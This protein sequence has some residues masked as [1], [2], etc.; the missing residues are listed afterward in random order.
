MELKKV[1]AVR[2]AKTVYRD[3][4]KA[5]K[6]FGDEYKKSDI[7]NEALNQ[8]RVEETGIPMPKLSL[9]PMLSSACATSAAMAVK[10]SS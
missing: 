3:G 8:A 7:L 2:T 6:V 10:N 5:I 4:D 9:S 1:I